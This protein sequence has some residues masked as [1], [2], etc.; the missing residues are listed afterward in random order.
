MR[1][2]RKKWMMY[3]IVAILIMWPVVQITQLLAGDDRREDADK[4]LYKVSAFQME[5]LSSYLQDTAKTRDTESLTA[6]RQ[7]L[8]TAHFT[9]DHLVLAYGESNLT[10]LESLNQLMQY[11]LRLQIGGQ[12]PLKSDELQA[13]AEVNKQFTEL[14]DAYTKLLSGSDIASSQNTRLEKVDQSITELLKKKQLQ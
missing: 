3:F 1:N 8:Y 2:A 7:S 4:L 12:R 14:Y 11:I 5:L 10:K 6:L 13:L 9:H